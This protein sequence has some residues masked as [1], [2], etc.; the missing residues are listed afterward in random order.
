MPARTS[1]S[2]E[3]SRRT[4]VD[5][6]QISRVDLAFVGFLDRAAATSCWY[7]QPH[8]ADRADIDE[9]TLSFSC[10][11]AARRWR[12]IAR[13]AAARRIMNL[14]IALSELLRES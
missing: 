5:V 9:P 6:L 8:V 4:L 7:D 1:C 2:I 11:L 12:A 10:A 3:R 13:P 14:F